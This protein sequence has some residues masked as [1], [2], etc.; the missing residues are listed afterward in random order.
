M[1]EGTVY[2]TIPIELLRY[3]KQIFGKEAKRPISTEGNLFEIGSI[4]KILTGMTFVAMKNAGMFDS[5]DASINKY[6]I[7]TQ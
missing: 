2:S 5:I 6:P 1:A 4:T 7:A 3:I